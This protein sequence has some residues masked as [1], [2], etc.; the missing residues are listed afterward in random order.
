MA[1]ENPKKTTK[2]KL[3]GGHRDRLR[4][5]F[6]QEGL[7]G[8]E[9]H[10]IL[11][12]ALFYALPRRDTNP[13]AHRLMQRFGSL[14]AVMEADPV[15]LATVEGM[16]ET[17]ALFITML[18]ALTRR[19][20]HDAAT[21]NK[22]P[23]NRADNVRDYLVPLMAGRT[24]EVFYVLCLDAQ[25]RLLFPALVTEGTIRQAHVHPRQVVEL[26]IRHKAAHVILAHNHPSGNPKASQDDILLTSHLMQA[27]NPID[28][29][30]LDHLIIAGEKVFSFASAGMMPK[31]R[32]R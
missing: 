25:C 7:D 8:F 27:L 31:Q 15:D 5:R 19:Y 10:Q 29:Q 12:L 32:V 24:E 23:L 28:V 26:V 13:I 17:A 3:H 4:N 11:E 6:A 16:G 18:P 9:D 2:T 1:Q 14:S 22:T 20:Q 21:R 30:V